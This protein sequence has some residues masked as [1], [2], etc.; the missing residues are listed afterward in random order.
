MGESSSGYH[1]VR[2]AT[3]EGSWCSD[4]AKELDSDW[5]KKAGPVHNGPA[6]AIIAPLAGYTYCCDIAAFAFKQIVPDRV[7]RVFVLRPSHV[8][9]MSGCGLTSCGRYRTPL[10]DLYV[11]T[12][13][14]I[15][16]DLLASDA[17]E[18]MNIRNEE[19]ENNIEMQIPFIDKAME[20]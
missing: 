14:K 15:N 13:G 17:F 19:S 12:Q 7:K 11:D 5:F 8:V 20:G 18:I 10:G 2:Q 9:F 3:H 16:N 6:R 4:N 1:R